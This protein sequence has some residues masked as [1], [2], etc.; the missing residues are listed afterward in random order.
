MGD[1]WTTVEAHAV[2]GRMVD[3]VRRT[4][5]EAGDHWL[6]NVSAT[7]RALAQQWQFIPQRVHPDSY[8]SLLLQ[9]HLADGRP[10]ALKIEPVASAQAAAVAAFARAGHGPLVYATAAESHA[11]LLEWMPG[12]PLPATGEA[13]TAATAAVR[14]VHDSTLLAAASP[15]PGAASFTQWMTQAIDQSRRRLHGAGVLGDFYDDALLD[16]DLAR[17]ALLP[18]ARHG[19][20]HGD[21]VPPNALLRPD[22]TV[23]F[24]DPDPHYGP[25]ETDLAWLAIRLDAAMNAALNAA[26]YLQAATTRDPALDRDLLGWLAAHIS[27]TYVAY[28]VAMGHDI[29]AGVLALAAAPTYDW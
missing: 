3:N 10:A 6:A 5:G 24:I 22:G 21:L 2:S 14:N 16:A 12:T 1:V 8:R 29:P 4:R 13:M 11:S 19:L 26:T 15:L 9:G 27:R 23:A 25:A 17:A 20:C 7:A 28:K 18:E